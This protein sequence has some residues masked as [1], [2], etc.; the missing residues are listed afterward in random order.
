MDATATVT[1]ERIDGRDAGPGVPPAMLTVDRVDRMGHQPLVTRWF[2]AAATDPDV[3]KS[4]WSCLPARPFSSCAGQAES[5][6]M[7]VGGVCN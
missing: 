5:D 7:T 4:R 3:I 6:R 2:Y 1:V